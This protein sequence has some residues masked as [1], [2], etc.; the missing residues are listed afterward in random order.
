MKNNLF[1]SKFAKHSRFDFDFVGNIK[2]NYEWEILVE[3]F[4]K[5]DSKKEKVNTKEILI[6]KRIHQIWLGRRELPLKYKRWGNSW[7]EQNPK[8]EYKLWNENNIKSLGIKGIDVYSKN[9][10]PGLR[11]DILRYVILNK[12]GGLYI[13]TDFEC[14]KPIPDD[15]L[16]YKFISGI[17]FNNKPSIANGMMMSVPN[18]KLIKKIIESINKSKISN[19][20]E[21]IILNSGPG[22]L[23]K[24][25]F[26]AAEFIK[27]E[28]LILP[29]NYFYPYPNFLLDKKSNKYKYIT[30]ESIGIHHWEMSWMKG[31]LF[32]RIKNKLKRFKNE[33]EDR[34]YE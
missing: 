23:T 30:K 7:K 2:N 10:N 6:P 25:Y 3:Q 20:I 11:S 27:E 15:L 33:L 13:D 16:I 31:N 29:S 12:F 5:Y 24:E 19:N 8:W 32:N 4:R 34:R 22:I 17:I 28:T 18:Y 21:D 9:I 1:N 14:L 26:K